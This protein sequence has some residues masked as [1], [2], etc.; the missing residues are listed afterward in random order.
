M[1]WYTGSLQPVPPA[2]MALMTYLAM[3]VFMSD[4]SSWFSRR[5]TLVE[6]QVVLPPGEWELFFVIVGHDCCFLQ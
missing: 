5:W 3:Q 2:V 1:K 6:E 4:L